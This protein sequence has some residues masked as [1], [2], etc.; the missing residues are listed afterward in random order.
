MSLKGGPARRMRRSIFMQMD[1]LHGTLIDTSPAFYT[2]LR[3]DRIG[4]IFFDLIDF[5]G[6]DL[7]TVSTAITFFAIHHW[8]HHPLVMIRN[9]SVLVSQIPSPKSQ[10]IQSPNL[11]WLKHNLEGKYF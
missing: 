4:F 6:T 5:T 9:I 10:T 3:M 1:R 7:G 2:I 8:D 11:Q